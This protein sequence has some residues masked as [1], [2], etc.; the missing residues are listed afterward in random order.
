MGTAS[1][2]SKLLEPD[3]AIAWDDEQLSDI[4]QA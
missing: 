4:D 3:P 1:I 2:A